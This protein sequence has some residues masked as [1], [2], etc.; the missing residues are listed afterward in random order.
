MVNNKNEHVTTSK[1]SKLP[2][3]NKKAL[4]RFI[5][6]IIVASALIL[7]TLV[8]GTVALIFTMRFVSS[9]ND[10]RSTRDYNSSLREIVYD[11]PISTEEHNNIN[12]SELDEKMLLINPDYICWIKVDGTRVDHPV[13]RGYDNMKYV[14]TS[15]RGESNELGAI[16]MDYRNKG[17]NLSNIIIYGHNSLQGEMFGDLHLL[18]DDQFFNDHNYITL[19]VNGSI[20]EFEIFS[21]RLSDINDRA[22]TPV[23]DSHYA[24]YSFADENGAPAYANKILTLSTCVSMGNDDLRLI[25]QGY[26]L[27]GENIFGS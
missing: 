15:F 16:F 21:V 5:R 7:I 10:Y 26:L 4:P 9:E 12:L 2:L 18:L 22:Y 19:L 23:F 14:S 24:F 13:V 17:D 8:V 20:Y 1:I 11:L 27:S 3:K 25:V 6:Q